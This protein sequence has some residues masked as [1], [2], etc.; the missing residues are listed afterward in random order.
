M[1]DPNQFQRIAPDVKL[2]KDVRI[3]AFTN[4][5]GCD[6][7]DE[8]KIAEGVTAKTLGEGPNHSRCR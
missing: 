8:T 7:G 3:F 4:L 6:I 2:G 1:S 5:Y